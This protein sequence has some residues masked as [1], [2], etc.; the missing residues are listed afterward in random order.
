MDQSSAVL[1]GVGKMVSP[2]KDLNTSSTYVTIHFGRNA[3]LNPFQWTQRLGE[4][5]SIMQFPSSAEYAYKIIPKKMKFDV[6]WQLRLQAEDMND[7]DRTPFDLLPG[8][9]YILE[10]QIT[11]N[12][13]GGSSA[14]PLMC[15]RV[16]SS[17]DIAS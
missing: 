8:E 12:Y 9:G 15:I 14:E 3:S 13:R 17:F 7:G 16:D 4:N 5:T 2:F 6:I 10:M 11:S 1:N